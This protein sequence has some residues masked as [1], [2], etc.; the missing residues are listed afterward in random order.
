LQLSSQLQKVKTVNFPKPLFLKELKNSNA[1]W[2]VPLFLLF[3]GK[4]NDLEFFVFCF[5][6]YFYFKRG[7]Q[8]FQ[9]SFHFKTS[10]TAKI[11]GWK[12]EK[13]SVQV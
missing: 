6:L 3:L 13:G 5:F 2:E 4:R 7:I 10:F 12:T 8:E 9:H 1:F 11:T